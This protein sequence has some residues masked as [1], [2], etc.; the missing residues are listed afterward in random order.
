MRVEKREGGAAGRLGS[1]TAFSGKKQ[2]E[3]Y[4]SRA[5]S[6][7]RAYEEQA[8]RPAASPLILEEERKRPTNEIWGFLTRKKPCICDVGRASER[9]KN[10]LEKRATRTRKVKN[11]GVRGES[12]SSDR[13][14]WKTS[15]SKTGK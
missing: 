10:G 11:L 3:T 13:D 2:K 4:G 9:G 12:R 8:V 5:C 7:L 15:T 6:R 14:R 1:T